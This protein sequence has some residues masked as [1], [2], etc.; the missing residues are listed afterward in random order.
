MSRSRFLSLSLDFFKTKAIFMSQP[1]KW[2]LTSP[3]ADGLQI[4]HLKRSDSIALHQ[5]RALRTFNTTY[6][7]N[8]DPPCFIM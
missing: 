7:D 3:L 2:E 5:R 4:H 8:K 6:Q 1:V